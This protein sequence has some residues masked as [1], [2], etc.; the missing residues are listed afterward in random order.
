[1]IKNLIARVSRTRFV[2][3][4]I[5]EGADLSAFRERPP[6]RTICG[7]GLI[8]LS[9]IIGWPMVGVLGVLSI[10]FNRPVLL[11]VGGPAVYILSH[12]V[13]L[14]GMYLAGVRYSF[15]FLRWLTRVAMLRLMKMADIPLPPSP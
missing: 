5:A 8:A 1:M 10:Y 11:V 3:G 15:I 13:F 7:V 6:A 4:A 14:L 9:Y 12:L 2:R